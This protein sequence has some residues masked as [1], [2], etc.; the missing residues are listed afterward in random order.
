MFNTVH[1]FAV[2]GR[3]CAGVGRVRGI[4]VVLEPEYRRDARRVARAPRA[5]RARGSRTCGRR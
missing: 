3:A 5:P 1:S 2:I 4:G